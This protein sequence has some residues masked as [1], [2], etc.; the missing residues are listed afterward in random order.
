MWSQL[1]QGMVAALVLLLF[2]VHA[3]F[4]QDTVIVIWGLAINADYR[5]TA[6][7]AY[8]SDQAVPFWWSALFLEVK[9]FFLT[10]DFI[11][12]LIM[13]FQVSK[14]LFT[15]KIDVLPCI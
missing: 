8:T 6:K 3:E 13:F 1:L 2:F 4:Q 5:I 11:N 7:V 9:F 15:F 12:K 14:L 10:K